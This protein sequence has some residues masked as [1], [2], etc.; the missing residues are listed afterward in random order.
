MTEYDR[1]RVG[2][3]VY[4]PNTGM[5]VITSFETLDVNGSSQRYAVGYYKH[6][7]IRISTRDL[8]TY[9][10]PPPKAEPGVIYGVMTKVGTWLSGHAVGLADGRVMETHTGAPEI[11]AFDPERHFKKGGQ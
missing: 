9:L 6:R 8:I 4:V 5:F 3:E 7:L 11:V 10:P 1:L 2:M